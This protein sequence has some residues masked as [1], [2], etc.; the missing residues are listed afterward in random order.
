[1]LSED[2]PHDAPCHHATCR[3]CVREDRNRDVLV[4]QDAQ[5]RIL[6][7]SP[8]IVANDAPPTPIELHPPE[9]PVTRA[10]ARLRRQ[11]HLRPLHLSDRRLREDLL[12]FEVLPT[13]EV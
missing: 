4:R 3:R 11:V 2:P 9:A 5:R 6:A 12:A 10:F 13:A 7:H 8:A 1:M